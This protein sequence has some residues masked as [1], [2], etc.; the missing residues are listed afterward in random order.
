MVGLKKK[1]G[2]I[3]QIPNDTRCNSHP[4][5]VKTFVTNYHK[6]REIALEN[7]GNFDKSILKILENIGIYHEAVNLEKQLITV[8]KALDNLQKD[9]T[10][11]SL[12]VEIWLDLL[13]EEILQPYFEYFKKRFEQAIK[14]PHFLANLMDPKFRGQRLSSIQEMQLKNG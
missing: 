14:P 11:I 4:E 6:Y 3:P 13:S 8:A 2:I 12:A 9:S 10:S 5:S 1:K 7:V